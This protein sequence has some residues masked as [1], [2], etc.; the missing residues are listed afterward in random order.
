MNSF[1]QNIQLRIKCI[2][3]IIWVRKYM[4]TSEPLYQQLHHQQ[5]HHLGRH[6]ICQIVSQNPILWSFNLENS[7]YEMSV[8]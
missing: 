5:Y 8:C 7:H 1:H 2:W 3:Q 6:K 4:K